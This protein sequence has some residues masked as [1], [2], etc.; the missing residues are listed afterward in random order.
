MKEKPNDGNPN[1]NKKTNKEKE[2]I[3]YF[4]FLFGQIDPNNAR[5]H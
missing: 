2:N 1:E 4:H 5:F 3:V